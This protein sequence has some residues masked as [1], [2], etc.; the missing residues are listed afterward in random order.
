V[1]SVEDWPVSK[2]SWSDRSVQTAS[3]AVWQDLMHSLSSCNTWGV[4]TSCFGSGAPDNVFRL[5]GTIGVPCIYYN[6]FNDTIQQWIEEKPTIS[7]PGDG[8]LHLAPLM[9]KAI[10]VADSSFAGA[11]T[12]TYTYVVQFSGGI[13][14]KNWLYITRNDRKDA[15]E[16]L[17]KAEQGR[18]VIKDRLGKALGKAKASF[19]FASNTNYTIEVFYDGSNVDVNI[20]GTPVIVDFALSRSLPSA[21]IGAAAKNNLLL[22]DSVCFQ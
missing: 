1:Q 18:L 10:A 7:Q 22:I 2:W 16:I 17:I 6:D 15:L 4:R 14:A 20:D 5:V 3:P 12:G 11:S 9:N 8:Y 21:N 13:N 19:A